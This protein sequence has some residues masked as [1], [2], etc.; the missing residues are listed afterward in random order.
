[1]KLLLVASPLLALG[2]ALPNFPASYGDSLAQTDGR[3]Q[4]YGQSGNSNNQYGYEENGSNNDYDQ[5]SHH[6]NTGCPVSITQREAE[7]FMN[8]ADAVEHQQHS[9]LGDAL[10]TAAQIL[11][12]DLQF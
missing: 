9:D 11:A 4:D 1:M 6:W 7:D 3:E 8:R 12:P 5:G 2:L 10:Q